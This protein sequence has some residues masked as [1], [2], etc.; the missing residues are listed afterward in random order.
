MPILFLTERI[1]PVNSKY[2]N[3]FGSFEKSL[4]NFHR[5]VK[6]FVTEEVNNWQ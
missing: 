3:S 4:R 6:A 1:I 5:Q 2:Q